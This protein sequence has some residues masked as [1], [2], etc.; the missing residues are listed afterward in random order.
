MTEKT[1]AQQHSDL[2]EL[3]ATQ[4]PLDP[5]LAKYQRT[6]EGM[7]VLQHPLVYGV[8]YMAEMNAVYN[9]ALEAKLELLER[10]KQTGHYASCL[11]LYERPWRLNAFVSYCSHLTPDEYWRNLG[12]IYSD[13][14]NLY[15]N[16]SEWRRVLSAG[17]PGREHMMCGEERAELAAMPERLTVY[18]GCSVKDHSGFSWTLE[19][20]VAE[21]FARRF[22]R[23]EGMVVLTATV[24][25]GDVIA[26]LTGRNEAEV[27][28]MPEHVTYEQAEGV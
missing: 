6:I 4:C 5:R 2:A 9:R 27:I 3:L 13:S 25:R 8:P 1:R 10:Y 7:P 11:T 24:D 14:E 16:R 22:K 26:Y 18:R 20:S 17:V 15:Q 23:E 19:R 12:W 28:A 21:W